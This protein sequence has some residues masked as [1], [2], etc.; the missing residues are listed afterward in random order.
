MVNPF[1]WLHEQ[2]LFWQ[3][4]RTAR[5]YNESLLKLTKKM[6]EA[7]KLLLKLKI[8]QAEIER[9]DGIKKEV[10]NVLKEIKRR[11]DK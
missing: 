9:K 7:Q 10:D 11:K 4:I 3:I 8:M 2:Y 5:K 1:K 6:L